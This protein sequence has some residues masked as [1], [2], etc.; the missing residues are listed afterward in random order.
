[1]IIVIPLTPIIG[2][3]CLLLMELSTVIAAVV[4]IVMIMGPIILI[5]MIVQKQE[6]KL[7][8]KWQQFAWSNNLKFERGG[9]YIT[10]PIIF[11]DFYGYALSI[12]LKTEHKRIDTRF[13]LKR[14]KELK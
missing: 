5:I 1:M 9:K 8:N 10:K 7:M 6:T 13:E 11:G 14:N 12:R 4:L 2:L 3:Y